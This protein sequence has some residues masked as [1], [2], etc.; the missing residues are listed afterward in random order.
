MRNLDIEARGP[1]EDKV[2]TS[3]RTTFGERWQNFKQSILPKSW[4]R[5]RSGFS[6][7]EDEDG[8]P[9]E[10]ASRPSGKATPEI[11]SG[12]CCD[13]A[14]AFGAHTAC[15]QFL[16]GAQIS[17]NWSGSHLSA[18]SY[19]VSLAMATCAA[20]EALEPL[21]HPNFMQAVTRQQKERIACCHKSDYLPWW[22]L[23]NA[24]SICLQTH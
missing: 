13:L 3:G 24:A 18:S 15:S 22:P 20:E 7:L 4:Q 16:H 2:G 1:E 14:V 9:E 19:A 17:R 5:D 10:T 12:Q 8:S 6:R 21:F 23:P 11:N